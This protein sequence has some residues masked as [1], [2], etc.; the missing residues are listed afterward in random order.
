VGSAAALIYGLGI[1]AIWFA[2]DT[3]RKSISE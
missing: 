2:P 3:T 1:F